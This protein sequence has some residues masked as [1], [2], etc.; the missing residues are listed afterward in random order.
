MSQKS[1]PVKVESRPLSRPLAVFDDLF[2]EFDQLLE[3]PWMPRLPWRL[4]RFSE[5]PSTFLPRIDVM[6]KN[7]SL[8]VQV[9]LPGMK[10]EEVHVRLEGGDLVLEGERKEESTVEKENYYKAECQYGSFYRRVPLSFEVKPEDVAA[11]LSDGVLEVTVPLPPAA[12]P[13][14]KEISIH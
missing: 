4:R 2:N 5:E 1:V 3:R 14:V 8:V 13:E 7:G 11:K 6:K 9:D 12:K 10:R